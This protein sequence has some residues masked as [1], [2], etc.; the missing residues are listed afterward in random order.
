MWEKSQKYLQLW[1][2]PE[3][4]LIVLSL[5]CTGCSCRLPCKFL[6]HPTLKSLQWH[7]RLVPTAFAFIFTL[8]NLIFCLLI[9]S[10]VSWWA[11]GEDGWLDCLQMTSPWCSLAQSFWHIFTNST[12]QICISKYGRFASSYL[13]QAVWSWQLNICVPQFP[14]LKNGDLLIDTCFS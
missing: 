3:Y 1:S 13:H 4:F 7:V 8:R 12:L 14:H 11:T 10:P 9:I 6:N 5:T 2:V